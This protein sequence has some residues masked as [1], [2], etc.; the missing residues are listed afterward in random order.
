[1]RSLHA[2]VLREPVAVSAH[3]TGRAVHERLSLL[4]SKN[5][6]VLLRYFVLR[7]VC[8]WELL[9]VFVLNYVRHYCGRV[10]SPSLLFGLIQGRVKD[11][12]RALLFSFLQF[13]KRFHFTAVVIDVA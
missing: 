9:P 1:M 3:R 6:K 7:L 11:C 13:L 2:S 8:L 12:L 5:V 10:I 4:F